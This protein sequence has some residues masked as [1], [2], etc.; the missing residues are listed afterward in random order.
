MKYGKDSKS[1]KSY[2]EMSADKRRAKNPAECMKASYN[3]AGS[4]E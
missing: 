2:N 4:N 1:G 3:A